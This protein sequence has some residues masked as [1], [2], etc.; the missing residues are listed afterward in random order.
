M[1]INSKPQYKE[2]RF[3]STSPK[4]LRP[5]KSFNSLTFLSWRMQ[6]DYNANPTLRQHK[7]LIYIAIGLR[8]LLAAWH[9][10]GVA[11]AEPAATRMNLKQTCFPN[12]DSSHHPHIRCHM[13]Q[14]LSPCPACPWFSIIFINFPHALYRNAPK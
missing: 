14:I 11:Q 6:H 13:R 4:R 3:S 12:Q 8:F 2:V 10:W 1:Q 5:T 7:Q 9:R